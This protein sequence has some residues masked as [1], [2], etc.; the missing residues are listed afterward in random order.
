MI[1]TV[2]DRGSGSQTLQHI[3]V[4]RVFVQG[5]VGRGKGSKNTSVQP[6]LSLREGLR[7]QQ[8]SAASQVAK[9]LNWSKGESEGR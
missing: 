9:N 1:E 7:H 6:T 2:A 5:F 4:S 3:G 8:F